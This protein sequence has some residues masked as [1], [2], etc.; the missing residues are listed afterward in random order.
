MKKVLMLAAFVGLLSSVS[1][2][3]TKGDDKDKK[4]K[5]ECCKKSEG[6]ACAG[7]KKEACAKGGETKA[8]CKKKGEASASTSDATKT[9]EEKK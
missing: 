4:G 6:K 7:E 5:K 8:C 2:A 3:A 9:A 1:V